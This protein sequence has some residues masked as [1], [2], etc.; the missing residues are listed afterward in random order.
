MRPK[1]VSLIIKKHRKY[2]NNIVRK[3]KARFYVN[4]IL[5]RYYRS[6]GD[7]NKAVVYA[8]KAMEYGEINP[9]FSSIFEESEMNIF[10]YLIR[11]MVNKVL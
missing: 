10:R 6:I 4:E 11:R 7:R 3:N 1:N 2:F 9:V 8:K 5:A